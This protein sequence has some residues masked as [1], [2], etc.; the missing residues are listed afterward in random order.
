[1]DPVER[2]RVIDAGARAF[3]HGEFHQAHE[4][5]EEAWNGSDG[6]ERR[7]I[8]GMIQLATGLYKLQQQR[9]DLCRSLLEKGI[10]KL[11]DAPASFDGHALAQ[12]RDDAL[13]LLHSLEGAVA[14]RDVT[15]PQLQRA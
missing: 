12:L 5:W 15:V 8:Q 14:G 3:N 7:W 1:M 2:R 6:S 9:A 11:N 13:A 4:L 10:A